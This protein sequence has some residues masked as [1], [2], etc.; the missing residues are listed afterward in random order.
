[1]SAREDEAARTPLFRAEA[2]QHHAGERQ[3][4]ELLRLSTSWPSRAYWPLVAAIGVGLV[5]CALGTVNEYASGPAVVRIEDRADVTATFAATV[6]QVLA[7]PG[8]HVEAGEPLVQF[9]AD[10]ENAERLR[11]ESEFELQVMRVMRD[12][13]DQAARQALTSLRAQKDLADARVGQRLVRAS[14]AGVVSDVRVRAGEHLNPGDLIVSIV[15]DAAP[16]SLTAVLPGRYRPLLRPGMALRFELDGE[17]YRYHDLVI[18]SVG[19]DVVGPA[20]VRRFLG[21]NAADTVDLKGPLVLVR[22]HLEPRATDD[23]ESL[24]Y[25]DGLPGRVDVKV[26]SESILVSLVPALREVSRHAR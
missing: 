26:R 8:Q 5:Y 11:L 17:R 4:G 14:R 19:D 1:M 20:E 7:R 18:E 12:P 13:A 9:V 2:L 16:V 6:A 25:F 15:G 10:D 21:A 23:G 24:R 3:E 22:A